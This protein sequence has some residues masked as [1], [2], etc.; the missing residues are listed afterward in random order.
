L[1]LFLPAFG[2][3]GDKFLNPENVEGV[4]GSLTPWEPFVYVVVA[5]FEMALFNELA[6][7]MG[8]PGD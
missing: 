5:V 3:H 7:G 1:A 2:A 8:L 4:G 6:D